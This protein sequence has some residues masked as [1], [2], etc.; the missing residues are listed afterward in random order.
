MHASCWRR[1]PGSG[2]AGPVAGLQ[3][4]NAVPPAALRPFA[5]KP[6]ALPGCLANAEHQVQR[7]AV[8]LCDHLRRG[9]M[10]NRCENRRIPFLL[11]ARFSP[12]AR[13]SLLPDYLSPNAVILRALI[14]AAPCGVASLRRRRRTSR[15]LWQ[16]SE[17]IPGSR[18]FRCRRFV[19]RRRAGTAAPEVGWHSDFVVRHH[20]HPSFHQEGQRGVGELRGL[21]FR[22]WIAFQ[23]EGSSSRGA[24]EL[25]EHVGPA[26]RLEGPVTDRDKGGVRDQLEH[27]ASV[28]RIVG[29]ALVETAPCSQPRSAAR[30]RFRFH[31]DGILSSVPRTRPGC[32]TAFPPG[33]R[34]CFDR[35]IC[36]SP[37]HGCCR[38]R[39]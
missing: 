23:S 28:E 27:I 13:S 33:F 1:L 14:A 4:S 37:S 38:K 22:R 20:H 35:G 34:R 24:R 36:S 29:K 8:L 12:H 10:S 30:G 5:G 21:V 32:L 11:P 17:K 18:K 7:Y 25:A 39:L 9:A 26:D 19:R 16:S 31:L 2:A 3:R 15:A 6:L